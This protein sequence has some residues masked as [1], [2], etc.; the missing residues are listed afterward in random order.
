MGTG[1]RKVGTICIYNYF[2][3]KLIHICVVTSNRGNLYNVYVMT[4]KFNYEIVAVHFW[5]T[6]NS[7]FCM[8]S[9]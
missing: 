7:L 8:L 4:F 3:I 9:V 6:V 5:D 2:H 1:Q